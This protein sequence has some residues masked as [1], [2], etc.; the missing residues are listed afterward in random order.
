M[1]TK[2]LTGRVAVVTGAGRG[3]GRASAERLAKMGASVVLAARSVHEL[4]ETAAGI[5]DAGGRAEV[6]ATDV[7]SRSEV[8]HLLDRTEEIFGRLD[9][10]VN[11]AGAMQ[12][13]TPV[14]ELAD[15]DWDRCFDVNVHGVHFC[16]DTALE[17]LAAGDGG[18]IIVI[19]SGQGHSPSPGAAAYCSAKAAVSMYVRVLARELRPRGITV[20]EIVPGAVATELLS[21]TVGLPMDRLAELEPALGGD[22]VKEPSEVAEY[23]AF[24]ATRSP[25]DGPT[26]QCF[27]LL[28]RDL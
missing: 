7:T 1:S 8:R 18:H 2:P 21:W 26:G 9:I 23:V 17:L 24:L 4:D 10:L 11:N 16:C 19:G 25:Q 14:G 12:P 13:L 20:N 28:G 3:I 27:S 22:R 6:I 15:E 5:T